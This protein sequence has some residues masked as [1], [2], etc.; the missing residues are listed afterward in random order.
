MLFCSAC[1]TAGTGLGSVREPLATDRPGLSSAQQSKLAT[2]IDRFIAARS[3]VAISARTQPL[4]PAAGSFRLS[5]RA[6]HA[7]Y[8]QHQTKAPN[9]AHNQATPRRE[10]RL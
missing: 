3:W 9:A 8:R 10:M 5:R 7:A 4:L 6:A 2:D 1:R